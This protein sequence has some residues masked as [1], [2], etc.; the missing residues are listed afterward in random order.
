MVISLI[1]YQIIITVGMADFL[2]LTI[3][4]RYVNKK[5]KN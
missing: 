3:F 4:D 5:S 2:F 1:I